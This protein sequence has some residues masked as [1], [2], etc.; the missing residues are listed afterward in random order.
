M[1]Q[2]YNERKKNDGRLKRFIQM[3]KSLSIRT[4]EGEVRV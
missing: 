2:K 4:R 1:R 3:K